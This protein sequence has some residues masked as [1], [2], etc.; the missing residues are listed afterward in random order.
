M[1]TLRKVAV[2]RGA[3]IVV[4]PT[5]L[6]ARGGDIA[7]RFFAIAGSTRRS[8]TEQADRR[9]LRDDLPGVHPYILM[10]FTGDRRS[11]LTLAHELGHGLHGALSL[12]LGLYNWARR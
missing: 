7:E 5:R 6:R 10:N 9:V 4:E 8:A 2:G 12:P 3:R 11:I 1:R